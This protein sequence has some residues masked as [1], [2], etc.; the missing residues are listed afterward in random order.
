MFS[1]ENVKFGASFLLNIFHILIR[2]NDTKLMGH[3]AHG[4]PEKGQI[5]AFDDYLLR[6]I[7]NVE[8][9][10]CKNTNACDAYMEKGSSFDVK[11]FCPNFTQLEAG[12][13]DS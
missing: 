6:L 5:S 4:G 10:D 11:T 2:I 1:D 8:Y 9:S 12:Q 7:R 13:T 3:F